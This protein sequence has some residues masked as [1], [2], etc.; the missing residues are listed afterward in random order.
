MPFKLGFSFGSPRRREPSERPEPSYH[1][2]SICT[3]KHPC[4]AAQRAAGARVLSAEALLLPLVD[5]DRRERCTCGYRHH[6]DRRDR[7][8]R[9]SE[10]ALPT[11][12]ASSD[13]ERRQ[14]TG[15]RAED[16]PDFGM[17][18]ADTDESSL[19]A[20]TYY[21]YGRRPDAG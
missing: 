1:A 6:Q 5:C 9:Q 14:A 11:A 7:P 21:G 19:V 3:G 16:R 15:R 12:P 4:A 18:E 13:I 2:V 8:R 10:G 20:D 17:D